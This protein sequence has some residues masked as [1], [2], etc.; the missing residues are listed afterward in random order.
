MESGF[1]SWSTVKLYYSVFYSLRA[2][3]AFG[4][5]AIFYVGQS[6]F[7]IKIT[8]GERP[9]A[10]RVLS[11][12]KLIIE[13]FDREFHNS[14]ILSQDIGFERPLVWLRN[15]RELV[16]YRQAKFSE[17]NVPSLFAAVSKSKRIRTMIAAYMRDNSYAFDPDHAILA[18]PIAVLKELTG[19]KG[20]SHLF[21]E[22]E[23]SAL[24]VI[25]GDSLGPINSFETIITK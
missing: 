4:H 8:P 22:N 15:Q 13:L 5:V 20:L 1:Y 11:S 3:L 12:H 10:G 16:N 25:L 7:W 6:P 9:R 23:Q 18:Y 24:R 14:P 21:D 2:L 17:P 19:K